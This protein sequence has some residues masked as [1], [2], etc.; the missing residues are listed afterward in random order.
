M[1]ALTTV[2]EPFAMQD[3]VN[4]SGGSVRFASRGCPGFL[5][6]LGSF[7]PAHKTR[8]MARREGDSLVEEEKLGP[9]SAGHDC[10][11]DVLVFEATDE[12]RL[13][14]PALAEQSL[15]HRIV[16]DATIAGE[17]TSLGY[18]DNFTEGRDAILKRHLPFQD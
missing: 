12:P 18:R 13:A 7:P 3:A 1:D 2:V 5:E 4:G 8:T 17:D 15:R 11:A 14:G 10:P 6:P 9:A 16:D